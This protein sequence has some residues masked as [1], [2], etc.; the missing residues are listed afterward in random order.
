MTKD[1]APQ[2]SFIKPGEDHNKID[3]ENLKGYKIEKCNLKSTDSTKILPTRV[4]NCTP[5]PFTPFSGVSA[6]SNRGVTKCTNSKKALSYRLKVE[7]F[8]L[9]HSFSHQLTV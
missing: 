9:K 6:L 2:K 3:L 8:I 7:F 5:R 1:A 4:A